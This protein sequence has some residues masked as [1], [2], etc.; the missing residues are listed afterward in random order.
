MPATRVVMLSEY[1]MHQ[2]AAWAVSG[3]RQQP[4]G[5]D[6]VDERRRWPMISQQ[7]SFN[8]GE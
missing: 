1:S 4:K 3:K 5:L 8:I 7:D 2:R 6:A